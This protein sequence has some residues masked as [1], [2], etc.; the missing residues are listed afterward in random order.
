MNNIYKIE[1]DEIDYDI[2]D[3]FVIIAKNIKRV[4]EIAS[5]NHAD[6]GKRIWLKSAWITKIGITELEEGIVLGSFRAG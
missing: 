4:R 1:H 2:Y 3:G 6:E 5:E